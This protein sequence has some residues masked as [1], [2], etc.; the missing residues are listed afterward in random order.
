[1]RQDP[2]QRICTWTDQIHLDSD[3]SANEISHVRR[4]TSSSLQDILWDFWSRDQQSIESHAFWRVLTTGNGESWSSLPSYDLVDYLREWLSNYFHCFW[5]CKQS[6]LHADR[7]VLSQQNYS[8]AL[9]CSAVNLQYLFESCVFSWHDH[10][11]W[12]DIW[13]SLWLNLDQICQ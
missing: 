1:M 9:S 7:W 2:N 5:K 10:C 12:N 13:N 4:A 8:Y 11:F 3:V 6:G